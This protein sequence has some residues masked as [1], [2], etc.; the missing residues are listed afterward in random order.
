MANELTIRAFMHFLKGDEDEDLSWPSTVTVSGTKCMKN[1]QTIGTSAEAIDMGD[2]TSQG[3]AMFINMD[4]TNYVSIR[5]GA[6]E[7]DL[8]DILAGE[9]AGPFRLATAAPYA[10]ADTASVELKYMIVEA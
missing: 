2:I 9:S 3:M 6:A 1:R 5:A 10:I 7:S 8:I 4:T